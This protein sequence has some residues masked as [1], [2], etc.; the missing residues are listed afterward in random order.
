VTRNRNLFDPRRGAGTCLPSRPLFSS[1]LI[2]AALCM[3]IFYILTMIGRNACQGAL[4]QPGQN[5]YLTSLMI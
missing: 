3:A 2:A 5:Q 4:F 1:L